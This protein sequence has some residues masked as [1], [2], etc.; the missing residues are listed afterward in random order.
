MRVGYYLL[1]G[2]PL[3]LIVRFISN[4]FD[5]GYFCGI[6]MWVLWICMDTKIDKKQKT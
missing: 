4:S 3:Y 1:I 5:V 2:I 6:G